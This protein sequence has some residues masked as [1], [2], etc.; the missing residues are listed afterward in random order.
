MHMAK[1]CYF[2]TLRT[3]PNHTHATY[4]MQVNCEKES[5]CPYLLYNGLPVTEYPKRFVLDGTLKV[6][7]D[8]EIG[9]IVERCFYPASDSRNC[10]ELITLKSDMNLKLTLSK[11]SSYVHAYGRG[12]KGVYISRVSHSAPEVIELSKAEVF[13]FAVS[14]SADV[15]NEAY[16]I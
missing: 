14:C 11:P 2:P 8:T 3:I 4:S 6:Y 5:D 1:S 9:L 12:T 10:M 15:A 7:S 16:T 13:S